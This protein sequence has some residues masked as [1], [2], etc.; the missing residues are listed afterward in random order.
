MTRFERKYTALYYLSDHTVLDYCDFVPQYSE[1]ITV[2][3]EKQKN[4]IK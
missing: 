3:D 1:Q 4:K 2:N